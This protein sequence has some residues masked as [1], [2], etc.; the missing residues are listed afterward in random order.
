MVNKCHFSFARLIV[1]CS[2]CAVCP[3]IQYSTRHW[4]LSVD[5]TSNC[6]VAFFY[7]RAVV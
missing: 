7:M 4:M 5:A 3:C 1:T 2:R 6:C